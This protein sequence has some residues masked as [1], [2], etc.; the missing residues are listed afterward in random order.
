MGLYAFGEVRGFAM[1]ASKNKVLR[2]IDLYS[3]VGGWALGLRM[4][5]VEVVSSYEIW[6]SANETNFKNNHHQAQ[7]VNIRRLALSELPKRIDIVV[8]S[9]PCT[10]FSYANRGGGGDIADGLED[11][12]KFLEIVAYLKPRAWA[13]E[14]VPRVAAI[15]DKELAPKGKLARFRSL[16][17]SHCIVNMEEFGLPQRRRRCIA[18]KFDIALLQSYAPKKAPTLGA[19]I[20]ALSAETVKDPIY[21]VQVE[22][23]ALKDHVTEDYL[24]EEEVRINRAAKTT[25]PVYNAMPFPD[26][27]NKTARTITA[28]CTRVSRESVVIEQPGQEGLYRRLTVRERASLQGFPVTFQFYG[29]GYSQKLRMVGNAFPPVLAYHLAQAFKNVPASAVQAVTEGIKSFVPPVPVPKTTPPHKAGSSFPWDR[30]FKFAVPSLRLKSGVRL[31]LRNVKADGTVSWQS[32]F[33]FGTPKSIQYL[34]LSKE[35]A[36]KLL[37]ALPHQ[38]ALKVSTLLQILSTY[39]RKADVRH[40][41]DVWSHKGPGGIRPF[42]L[43]DELCDVGT[44]VQSLLAGEESVLEAAI[45]DAVKL[46]YQRKTKNLAGRAKLKRHAIKIA[47][48]IL[49]GATVND[50]LQLHGAQLHIDLR[51]KPS[52]MNRAS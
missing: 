7:T 24:D 37:H 19:V 26:P 44:K 43:L 22:R 46:Q 47:A 28:T 3:G 35:Q 14:N 32:A 6:G 51:R 25:H 27:L 40:M 39:V 2:A 17:M 1:K 29:E 49:I 50:A 9:P 31:E 33:V 36:Q 38:L 5:G 41:Q 45:D 42:M 16:G 4:A 12:I 13:M 18:G 48:G 8:G 52:K 15:L 34:S 10:Q 20:A 11:I 30:T 23:S 21:G